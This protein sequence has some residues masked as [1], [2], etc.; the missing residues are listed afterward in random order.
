MTKETKELLLE[1]ATCPIKNS[2]VD[3]KTIKS[4]QDDNETFQCAE[5]WNGNIEK[6]KV[7][8]IS[9]NPSYDNKETKK[10]DNPY[11]NR[12]KTKEE[13]F[14]DFFENRFS[15][16]VWK[17]Y[18]K[19]WKRIAK[20]A[21]FIPEY[22]NKDKKVFF[23]EFVA[24]TEIVHCKSTNEIGV[25]ESC[26]KCFSLWTKKILSRF[27]GKYIVL[28]GKFALERYLEIKEIIKDKIVITTEH[29]NSRIKGNTDKV[30]QA[31]FIKQ[32]ESQTQS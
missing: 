11:P 15:N 21:T 4:V 19:F 23:Q 30:R 5:A 28:V 1:I 6:A 27:N 16:T 3:C 22:K 24:S 25:N 12:Q 26:D 31:S 13:K 29:P 32:I 14:I 2:F 10:L 17:D 18:P 7:L 9:S 20:F 8:F